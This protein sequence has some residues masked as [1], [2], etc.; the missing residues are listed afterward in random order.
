MQN[1]W[2]WLALLLAVGGGGFAVYQVN[3]GLTQVA[4]DPSAAF[5]PGESAADEPGDA[6]L[7]PTLAEPQVDPAAAALAAFD[8]AGQ[9]SGET[10][11]GQSP[12][13]RQ[14]EPQPAGDGWG[15]PAYAAEQAAFAGDTAFA[16]TPAFDTE[17]AGGIQ[18]AGFQ[19]GQ[20]RS[21]EGEGGLRAGLRRIG[22]RLAGR[23]RDAAPATAESQTEPG[24]SYAELFEQQAAAAGASLDQSVQQTNQVVQQT[25]QQA[26][27]AALDVT[28]AAPETGFEFDDQPEVMAQ[29]VQAF[30]ADA[31]A[32]DSAVSQEF[33]ANAFE[34]Q[35]L[36][37][38]ATAEFQ[39]EANEAAATAQIETL[40]GTVDAAASDLLPQA[41]NAGDPFADFLP[42]TPA[43]LQPAA[44]ANAAQLN[45]TQPAARDRGPGQPFEVPAAQPNLDA[46][47]NPAVDAFAGAAAMP[48]VPAGNAAQAVTPTAGIQS[49]E[50][51]EVPQPA[52]FDLAG[53]NREAQNAATQPSPGV[54]PIP[55]AEPM[56]AMPPQG[57]STDSFTANP[58]TNGPTPNP[59]SQEFP[60]DLTGDRQPTYGNGRFEVESQPMVTQPTPQPRQTA[61]RDYDDELIGR[62]TIDRDVSRGTVQPEL[63]ILKQAPKTASIGKPMVYVITVRNVGRSSAR[64]VVV[65][66]RI[67]KGANLTG[68]NPRGAISEGV[69][70]WEYDEIR[71]NEEKVIKVRIE[72]TASG[73]IGSITTVRMVA[74]TAA[75]TVVTAPELRVNLVGPEEAQ[76]GEIVTYRYEIA[77]TGTEDAYEVVLNSLVPEG[78]AHARGPDIQY[79]V[80]TLRAGEQKV[81]PLPLRVVEVGQYEKRVTLSARGNQSVS[82]SR[83]ISIIKSRLSIN[84][85][86]PSRRFVGSRTEF[87]NVVRNNSSRTLQNI[88]VVEEI[89]TGA[90]FVGATGEG[91]PQA[92]GRSIVWMIPSL[93]PGASREL[94]TA[95]VP[96]EA[97]MAEAV[98]KAEAADGSRAEVG[99]TVEIVGFAS[100]KIDTDHA[101]RPF[102]I[103]EQ[104]PLK[105]RVANGGSAP[106]NRVSVDVLVP[107]NLR[108]IEARGPRP[109]QIQGGT[110]HF[111]P[112]PVIQAGEAPEIYLLVE[113]IAE[114]DTPLRLQLQSQELGKPLI[115]DEQFSTYTFDSVTR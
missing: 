99:S 104:L 38:Q 11:R 8:T 45:A 54:M 98:V 107:D 22:D 112:I 84:R 15:E 58:G 102:A 9:A 23:S 25:V 68:S 28:A 94:Q 32:A 53:R 96:K 76:L 71:S 72:P 97:G 111:D 41:P 80:G 3:E 82:S 83:P 89:P 31:F 59:M 5:G 21:R 13:A 95:I 87:V 10:L 115:H 100:L 18:P 67:P 113:A 34:P 91:R 69:L 7:R 105:V 101:N 4:G 92:G 42:Q 88:R 2:K 93:A 30:A 19:Q 60:Q 52:N 46:Q 44:Q 77:N 50:F 66:D 27:A 56:P 78:L 64:R 70:S 62:S 24:P 110:V 74:E 61:S 47:P 43:T 14:L 20:P 103:G 17:S 57:F 40:G 108:V 86:G 55:S 90:E 75:E 12:D 63:Q 48:E 51:D 36:A 35:A 79:E 85:S 29:D 1:F 106:A 26:G 6:V 16:E 81:V 73:Q 109:H 49:Y 37:A 39:A 33:A 65:E 114:G